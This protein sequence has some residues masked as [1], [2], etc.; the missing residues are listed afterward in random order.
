[1]FCPS[2]DQSDGQ[3][4]LAVCTDICQDLRTFEFAEPNFSKLS[5]KGRLKTSIE[6]WRFIG[7]P[8]FILDIISDGNKIPFI[9]TPPPVH[10][11]NNGSALAH[12]GFVNDAILEL[13]QDNRIEELITPPEIINPLSVSVQSSGKKRLILDLR[14][15]NLHVFKQKFKCEGLH[16]IRDIFSKDYF[17]FSFDLKS[18]YRHVDIFPDHRKFLAFSWHFGTNCVRYFHFTVL[19]FGLSSVPFNFTKLIK[20]SEAF[21]R[22]QGIPIAIFFP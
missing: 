7:A 21:W 4:D 5:V 12:S 11:K 9:T 2:F 10:L 19:P 18:G 16:T 14:R 15:I 13:L 20:P 8:E 6:Y 22:L 1:M 17:V 3:E